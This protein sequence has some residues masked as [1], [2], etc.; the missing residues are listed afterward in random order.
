MAHPQS[1]Q[2]KN[3]NNN[4][5]MATTSSS[6]SSTADATQSLSEE[7][8]QAALTLLN[9]QNGTNLTISDLEASL[10]LTEMKTPTNAPTIPAPL[11]SSDEVPHSVQGRTDETDEERRVRL[12]RHAAYQRGLRAKQPNGYR[13]AEYRRYMDKETLGQRQERLRR[14]REAQNRRRKEARRSW[15]ERGAG[16][17]EEEEEEGG[18]EDLD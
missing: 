1:T 10:S 5:I 13:N 4:N 7:D 8:L 6:S 17:G 18:E 14:K 16:Q 2:G 15:A 12:D 3:K 11:I 9:M